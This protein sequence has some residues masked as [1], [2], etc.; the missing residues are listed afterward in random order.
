[1]SRTSGTGWTSDKD[2]HGYDEP[3]QTSEELEFN[4]SGKPLKAVIGVAVLVVLALVLSRMNPASHE[5]SS[6][7]SV[8]TGQSTGTGSR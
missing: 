5:A 2:H 4:Q 1:M 8:T 7:P 3:E 6:P